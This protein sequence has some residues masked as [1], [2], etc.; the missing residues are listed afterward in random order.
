MTVMEAATGTEV[1]GVEVEA[2][3]MVREVN[4]QILA[5]TAVQA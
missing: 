5:M 4:F 3:K 2:T 1:E